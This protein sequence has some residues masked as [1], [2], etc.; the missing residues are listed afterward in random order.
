MARILLM[1]DTPF[2]LITI[3]SIDISMP[4][5]AQTFKPALILGAV[6]SPL[7]DLSDGNMETR[8]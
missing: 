4:S 1:H 2:D 8:L 6:K 5:L 7:G 3:C